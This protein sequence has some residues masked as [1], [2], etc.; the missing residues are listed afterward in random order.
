MTTAIAAWDLQEL[1]EGRYRLGLG[2]LIAPNIIQKYSTAWSPPAP[3]MREYVAAIRAMFRSW[4]H[5]ED[6]HFI[7]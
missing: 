7:S 6:Y 1:S 3:R 5:G 2:P 4:Q